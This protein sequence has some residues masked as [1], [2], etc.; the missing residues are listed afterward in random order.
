MAPQVKREDLVVPYIHTPLKADSGSAGIVSQ[1]MPMAA[2]FMRNKLLSW[3]SLIS[4]I[5]SVLNELNGEPVAEGAQSGVMRIGLGVL[6]L[7]VCYMELALPGSF[8]G[9][10]KKA[11]QTAAET[12]AGASTTA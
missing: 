10:P 11:I 6:G 2:M 8:G 3:F 5:Q 9:A 1:S 7:A 4:S 12:V